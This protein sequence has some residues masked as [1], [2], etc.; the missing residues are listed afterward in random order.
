MDDILCVIEIP[1]Y[2]KHILLSNKRRATYYMKGEQIPKRFLAKKYPF[3]KKNR[4]VDFEGKPIIKNQRTV[5]TPRLKKINGQDIYSGYAT[6]HLRANMVN[7]IKESF[8]QVLKGIP[9]VNYSPVRIDA[10]IHDVIGA[11]NWDLDN[12]WIYIKC[13]QD[14]LTDAGIIPDDTIE[15][16]TK[17]PSFEFF[18]APD[19]DSRKMVFIIR[20]ELRQEILDNPLYKQNDILGE[21]STF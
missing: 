8:M 11:A 6:H 15:Y 4:M 7:Q 10:E 1:K 18:P 19:E 16:V 12:L 21:D 5:G 9:R 13:M 17:A 20:K 2:I 3:D 14:C